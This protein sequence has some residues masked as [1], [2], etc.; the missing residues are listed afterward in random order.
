MKSLSLITTKELECAYYHGF[1][2]HGQ[3][4]SAWTPLN[5]TVE[6]Y[7]LA[8]QVTFITL[9]H[10]TS[11]I[12]NINDQTVWSRYMQI[13]SQNTFYDQLMTKLNWSQKLRHILVYHD[14][15]VILVIEVELFHDQ[16]VFCHRSVFLLWPSQM[17][18]KFVTEGD[19]MW[20]SPCWLLTWQ[21]ACWHGYDDVALWQSTMCRAWGPGASQWSVDD[22]SLVMSDWQRVLDWLLA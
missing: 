22:R 4:S 11:T 6:H 18:T 16:H 21:G 20:H 17:V 10:F 8:I 3:A 12:L 1:L 15:L 19:A 13:W 2:V 5:S 14:Q 7:K 9:W